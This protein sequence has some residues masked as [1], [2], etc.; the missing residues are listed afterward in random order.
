MIRTLKSR[1]TI[2]TFPTHPEDTLMSSSK[3]ISWHCNVCGL[4]W[5]SIVG[6]VLRTRKSGEDAVCPKC[7]YL[8]RIKNGVVAD[9][10]QIEDWDYEKNSL[11]TRNGDSCVPYCDPRMTPASGSKPAWWKCHH[12]GFEWSAVVGSRC[13]AGQGCPKCSHTD[14]M[15]AELDWLML[16]WDQELNDEAHEKETRHGLTILCSW[17]EAPVGLSGSHAMCAIILGARFRMLGR[18][19]TGRKAVLTVQ[20]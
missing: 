16:D 11:R 10:P 15:V 13:M 1:E 17:Q 6:S 18:M 4:S 12:C 9:R 7:R 2:S 14:G 20:G 5:E 8:S 19:E 3:L